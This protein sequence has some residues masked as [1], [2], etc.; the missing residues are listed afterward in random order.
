M[1]QLLTVFL[2]IFLA[3]LGDKTQLGTVLFASDRLLSRGGIF[4]AASL[5]LILS[6]LMAVVVGDQISRVLSP[7]TLKAVAGIGFIVIGVGLLV[8]SRG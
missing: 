4:I 7:A 3:E 1:Q 2:T 5:A 6:S 8:G